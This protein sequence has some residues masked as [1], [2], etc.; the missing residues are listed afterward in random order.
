MARAHIYDL[1]KDVFLFFRPFCDGS[2]RSEEVQERNIPSK[3]EIW[4]P[5]DLSKKS[6]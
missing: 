3:F 6:V 1:N 2:H 4:E 5:R